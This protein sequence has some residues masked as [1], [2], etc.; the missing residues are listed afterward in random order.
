MKLFEKYLLS[1]AFA[2]FL[3][4]NATAFGAETKYYTRVFDAT[5]QVTDSKGT[6]FET[7]TISDGKG[8][9]RN[10]NNSA[11]GKSTTV[12]DYPRKTMSTVMEIQKIIKKEPLV[13]VTPPEPADSAK[14]DV[15]SLGEKTIAGHPCKGESYTIYKTKMEVWTGKDINYPVKTIIEQKD[16]KIT[17]ELK[18]FSS[19][20]PDPALFTVPSKGYKVI[21]RVT[22]KK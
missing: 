1:A 20:D 17:N 3:V 2:G 16:S 8:H 19:K 21:D 10:E 18:N 4:T 6:T 13:D 14:K 5:N 9:V 22:M 7:R 15:K 11:L 12:L